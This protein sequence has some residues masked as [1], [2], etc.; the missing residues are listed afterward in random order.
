MFVCIGKCMYRQMYDVCMRYRHMYVCM[1][2]QMH[3][4]I[5]VCMYVCMYVCIGK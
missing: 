4:C 1:S 2:R 3:A 5:Y